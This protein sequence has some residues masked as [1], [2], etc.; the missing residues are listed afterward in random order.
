MS[1]ASCASTT[2]A[3]CRS[4]D[5]WKLR[6]FKPQNGYVNNLLDGIWLRAPYLHNGSVPTLRDLLTEP[7]KRPATFCRGSDVYDWKNVGFDAPAPVGNGDAACGMHFLYNTAVE[8]NSNRGHAYGTD[9]GDE[10]KDA[11]LEFMKTL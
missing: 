3:R 5:V 4:T 6:N 7:A 10:D 9:L 2:T 11:L 8:G 1:T